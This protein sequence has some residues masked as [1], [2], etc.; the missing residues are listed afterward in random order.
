MS[1]PAVSEPVG[2]IAAVVEPSMGVRAVRQARDWIP[3]MVLLIGFL[4]A[5]ELTV[6]V[7]G[8][9]QFILPRPTAIA[10][11]WQT[12]LP[13]LYAAARYTFLEIVAGL[14]IGATAG[15]VVGTLTARFRFMQDS[16]MPFAVAAS[17][18]PILAFAP[19]FNNWFGLDQQ[20]SKAMVAA[21][22]CFFPVMI[23]TV[24]GLTTVDPR[25][26]ELFRAYATPERAVFRK[27]RVPNALPYIFT[28]LRLAVT[29]ATIGAVVGEYFAA[30]RASLGQYIATYSAFLN[31]E[32]SW[33]AIVFACAIGIGLYL[34]VVVLERLVMPWYGRQAAAM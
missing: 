33:A 5:W 12:Y 15:I 2:A 27:L 16:L 8:L 21:V 3:P 26:L 1:G 6:R 28:S 17:S 11:A 34:V 22:L 20:L 14:L 10:T 7:L 19:L 4:V 25:A 29:L 30:P 13:E 23:N 32:R 9:K 24:R 18:V 31:F